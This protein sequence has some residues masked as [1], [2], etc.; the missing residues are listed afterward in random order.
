MSKLIIDRRSEFANRGRKIGLYLNKEKIGTIKNGETRE[1][2]IEPGQYK[3]HARIDWCGSQ[4]EDISLKEDE[5]KAVE[6]TGFSKNRWVLQIL[7]LIQ[8]I[9]IGLTYLID[10]NLYLM[11]FYSVGVMLYMSYPITFGRNHYLK[12][13]EK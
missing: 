4:K 7:I 6:L 1:F 5:T 11:I 13:I 3:L 2:E 10:I 9:L 8:F 12:L